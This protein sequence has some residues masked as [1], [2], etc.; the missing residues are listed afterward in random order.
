MPTALRSWRRAL[1]SSGGKR[2]L[3]ARHR[4]PRV[5]LRRDRRHERTSPENGDPVTGAGGAGAGRP[6]SSSCSATVGG[7]GHALALLRGATGRWGPGQHPVPLARISLLAVEDA[8]YTLPQPAQ[9]P[10]FG[11]CLRRH[12]RLL[13]WSA[14]DPLARRGT[15]IRPRRSTRQSAGGQ[16]R[17]RQRDHPA[18][19]SRTADPSIQ[20]GSSARR[21]QR[22]AWRLGWFWTQQH[23]DNFTWKSSLPSRGGEGEG[24]DGRGAELTAPTSP[25]RSDRRI[26]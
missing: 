8:G 4:F 3:P 24:E 25:L 20:R 10:G 5:L 22:V 11:L 23:G 17:R 13:A 19:T 9:G 12:P 14:A 21:S 18:R 26:G 16:E 6:I 2:G 1:L 15:A 7:P